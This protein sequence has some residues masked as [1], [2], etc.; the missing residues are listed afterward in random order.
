MNNYSIV[1]FISRIY[2]FSY[3]PS[4]RMIVAD[5]IGLLI[6]QALPKADLDVTKQ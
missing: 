5:T 6:P 3:D 2:V 4:C 1:S